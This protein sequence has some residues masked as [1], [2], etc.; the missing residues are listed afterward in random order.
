MAV[1]PIT[2]V[3][4]VFD[5]DPF[6]VEAVWP[7]D[8][9]EHQETDRKDSVPLWT[10]AMYQP[11][12]RR[13]RG[14]LPSKV[15]A[16]VLDLDSKPGRPAHD[17]DATAL[18]FEAFEF[19]L[20]TTHSHKPEL[21]CF[22][23]ILP[24]DT[25]VPSS[26]YPALWLAAAKLAGGADPG[27]KDPTRLY[28]AP[29]CLPGAERLTL[30]WQGQGRFPGHLAAGR[31][32]PSTASTFQGIESTGQGSFDVETLEET[33][34]FLRHARDDA[35]TLPEPEWYAAL[36]LWGRCRRGP[37]TAHERSK[38]HPK[39]TYAETAQKLARALE[40]GP[41]TCARIQGISSA[42]VGC[43][44]RVTSPVQLGDR[45]LQAPENSAGKRTFPE[46]PL[47]QAEVRREKAARELRAAR[48]WGTEEGLQVAV[49]E[50]QAAEA[51]CKKL[52]KKG[53]RGRA[54]EVEDIIRQLA[55]TRE[56]EIR[57][58]KGNLRIIFEQD[59]RY[60]E[61]FRFDAFSQQPYYG[62]QAS[63]DTGDTELSTDLEYRYGLV[64]ESRLVCEVAYF[65]A[66]Q[67]TFH[68]VRDY[69]RS[70]SWDGTARVQDLL[71]R[72]F[73]VAHIPGKDEEF[74]QKMAVKFMV[75]C[76]ARIMDPG[77]TVQSML[78]LTGNQGV[79]KSRGLQALVSPPCAPKQGW[80]V[81]SKIEV[82]EKDGVMKLRGALLYEISELDSFRKVE[83]SRLK[84]WISS[85]VDRVRLPWGRH[86]VDIPRETVFVGTTNDRHFLTDPTGSRRY[87]VAR[88]DTRVD[89][90]WIVENRDQLWAEAL[91]LYEAG[92]VWYWDEAETAQLEEFNEEYQER[93]PWEEIIRR[94]LL[95]LGVPEVT[96]VDVLLKVLMY[97][98]DRITRADRNRVA[99]ALRTLG[100]T[101]TRGSNAS[102]RAYTFH[103]P[104]HLRVVTVGG[105]KGVVLE[106]RTRETRR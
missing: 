105:S 89:I 103:I 55:A 34:A 93:D 22:R 56:G 80:F 32:I 106:L 11:G 68:P 77:C 84:S 4:S 62:A 19:V 23:I 100:C 26:Q 36:S 35:A 9:E 47:V 90:P 58:T 81:D 102:G 44:L 74:F 39:Y 43:T 1:L 42:C 41:A 57:S 99:D 91:H 97:L 65:V 21:P 49:E 18:R 27:T 92:T 66:K 59:P 37:E 40:V 46:D 101:P 69:L 6:P 96:P 30:H 104:E 82:G 71:L 87:M 15:S 17:L 38:A 73:Q 48:R 85:S 8:F 33:C 53:V 51:E 25:P 20:Y 83:N 31:P 64:A 28:F 12:E 70:T 24:L 79:G 72:G 67:R 54:P 10:P 60:A 98:P 45:S 61:M 88:V 13:Q 29:S 94:G 76:V 7:Q 14:F 75:S 78:V 63:S 50:H 95:Q 52:R 2:I 3:R 5:N 16:V 86:T